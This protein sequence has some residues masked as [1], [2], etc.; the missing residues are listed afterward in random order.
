VLVVTITADR[1]LSRGPIRSVFNEK[2][3][4]ESVAALECVDYVVINQWATAVEAIYLLKPDFYMRELDSE[5]SEINKYLAEEQEAISSLGG[6]LISVKEEEL[7]PPNLLKGQF[8]PISRELEEF[9]EEFNKKFSFQ[10]V[11]ESLEKI[12]DV[13]TL[14]IGEPIIDEYVFCELLQRASKAP[15][16]ATRQVYSE[17][18]AGGVL[19]VANH[20]ASFVHK[21]GLVGILGKMNSQEDFIHESL[22]SN[23][24]FFHVFREDSPTIVKKRFLEKVYKQKMF[25]VCYFNNYPIDKKVE[26]ETIELLN[27][28]IPGYDMIICADFGHGFFTKKIIDTV[29]EHASYLV[30]MAQSNSANFGYNP[31]TKYPKADYVVIDYVELRLACQDQ[32]GELEPLIERISKLLSCPRINITLGHEGTLFYNSDT[33][34]NGTFYK[35]P[36]ASWKV[37]DTIG[38]GDA[39]LAITSPLNYLNLDPQMIAFIGNCAGALAVQYLGNKESVEPISLKKFIELLMR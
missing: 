16:I 7:L 17:S 6:K 14:I 38:A 22:K 2:Q 33:R 21:I 10:E 27:D 30:V 35:V 11:I 15:T 37:I 34:G 39:V 12:R 13:R 18:Y 20:L 36:V 29:C 3:R 1:Y 8:G 23:I 31:I 9:L 19:A 32:H 25:E 28:L 24:K 26:S 4:A 5:N